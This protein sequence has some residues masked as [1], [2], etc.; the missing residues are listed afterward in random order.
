MYYKGLNNENG[1]SYDP[2]DEYLI[3]VSPTAHHG[4]L[5]GRSSYLKQ[6]K[7]D[8]GRPGMAAFFDSGA[9]EVR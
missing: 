5:H 6:R 8:A 2:R 3:L 1:L 9:W 7:D 4:P